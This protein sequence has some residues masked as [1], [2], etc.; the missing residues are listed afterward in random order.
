MAQYVVVSTGGSRNSGTK[1]VA[2][3]RI[4]ER[5]IGIMPGVVK[6]DITLPMEIMR[7]GPTTVRVVNTTIHKIRVGNAIVEVGK[8]HVPAS[9]AWIKVEQIQ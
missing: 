4:G 5:T 6:K 7:S 8:S 2:Q 1:P 9:Q 3:V